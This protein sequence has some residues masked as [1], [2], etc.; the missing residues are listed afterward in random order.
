MEDHQVIH[1]LANRL[2]PFGIRPHCA[3]PMQIEW[4]D[5]VGFLDGKRLGAVLRFYQAEWLTDLPRSAGWRYYFRGARTPILN[6]G[7]AI[8][9]ESKRFPLVWSD[10][11]STRLATWRRLLPAC[12][13]P[14]HVPWRQDDGWLLKTALCNTGDTVS[15]RSMMTLAKWAKVERSVR[16]LPEGWVAQRRFEPLP[17]A[18]PLGNVYPCIGVYTVDGRA[19]GAYARL[20]R[21]PV[22]D[23]RAVDVALLIEGGEP[24]R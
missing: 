20:S 23:Y 6:P 5:G 18:T 8:L 17:I 9:S 11:S 14:R 24:C 13:D 15:V 21:T 19:C 16:W 22:V 7:R 1:Y 3:Q 10:L 2:R 12:A 4:I